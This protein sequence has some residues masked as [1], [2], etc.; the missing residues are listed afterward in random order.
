MGTSLLG[1]TQEDYTL[2]CRSVDLLALCSFDTVVTDLES[3]P[4][5]R[6]QIEFYPEGFRS[7]LDP[8]SLSLRT[9]VLFTPEVFQ[10]ATYIV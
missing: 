9:I 5:S 3:I 8:N 7:T 10:N 6:T 4:D 2:C 1:V